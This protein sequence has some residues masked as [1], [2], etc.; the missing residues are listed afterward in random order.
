MVFLAFFFQER[1]IFLSESLPQNFVYQYETPSKEVFLTTSDDVKLNALHFKKKNSIGVVLYFHG[2]AGNLERWAGLTSHLRQYS[3]DLFLLDYR[4]YGKSGGSYDEAKMYED[5]LL[6][7]DYLNGLYDADSI[8]IYGR[9]LGST[10]G[11]YVAANR[12]SKYLILETPFYGLKQM[13]RDAYFFFA[14]ENFLTYEFPTFLFAD[15]VKC[16][17]YMF[18]GTDDMIVPYEQSLR[19]KKVF[20]SNQIELI[21]VDGGHHND[22]IKFDIYHEWI[23]RIFNQQFQ[24]TPLDQTALFE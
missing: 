8:I 21:T 13:L 14:I 10:F 15:Q 5:A 6:A 9:S 12:T 19:L 18:H 16:P 7:Y 20:N 17:I 24:D 4:G 1:F 23:E 22:L 11:T 2:N 3:Y